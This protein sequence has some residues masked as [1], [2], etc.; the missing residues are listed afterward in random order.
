M[1]VA[2]CG[3]A[4]GQRYYFV[5][6]P[7]VAH[8]EV[9]SSQ[10]IAPFA[11]EADAQ[12]AAD[13]LTARFPGNTCGIGYQHYSADHSPDYLDFLFSQARGDLAAVMTSIS[14]TRG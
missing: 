11:S 12:H 2:K 7:A 9:F 14:A 10:R 8:N 5:C 4:K 13:L 6:T 3:A 1:S